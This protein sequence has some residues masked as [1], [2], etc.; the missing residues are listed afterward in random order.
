MDMLTEASQGWPVMVYTDRAVLRCLGGVA[1]LKYGL[2][3]DTSP[4][5]LFCHNTQ[6]CYMVSEVNSS[7]AQLNPRRQM[8]EKRQRK[9]N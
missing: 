7:T 2:T 3:S 6:H 4:L 1:V 8:E 9:D 5:S